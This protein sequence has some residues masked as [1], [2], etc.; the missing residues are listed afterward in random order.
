MINITINRSGEFTALG[1]HEYQ[2]GVEQPNKSYKYEVRIVGTRGQ[3]DYRGF[4]I[5]NA[6]IQSYFDNHLWADSCEKMVSETI[7]GL[8]RMCERSGFR[9]KKISVK[10]SGSENSSCLGEY[11]RKFF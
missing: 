4:L 1:S 3:L 7:E 9:P 2:C 11:K 5:D 6:D 10:I 8:K